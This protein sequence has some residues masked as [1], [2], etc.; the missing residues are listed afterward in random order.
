MSGDPLLEIQNLNK[1]YGT[2][3]ALNGLDMQVFEGDI[4][5]F[6][7]PN[8]SGKSTTIRIILTLI[9]PDKGTIR[10]WKEDLYKRTTHTKKRLGALVEKPD[11]YTYL[12]AYKNLEILTKVGGWQIS[13]KQIMETLDVV[14]LEEVWNKPVKTF[15]QGMRQR[16]GIAQAILHD[17]DLLILDE[18]ANGLDPNGII[19]MRNLILRLNKELNKTIIM[20]SHILKE[21]ELVSNR[22]IV[23]HKGKSV[24]EGYVNELLNKDIKVRI[25][26]D[27][28]EKARNCLL[29]T[30]FS[31][32]FSMIG[33]N[34][35]EM[36]MNPD[37]IPE[38]IKSLVAVDVDV[39][40]A[41][42]VRSLEDY[43]LNIT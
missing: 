41:I 35:I 24:V 6:L 20:S 38:I 42:P 32:N 3:Q 23:I 40:S 39:K 28:Q 22:M 8:G 43:Y 36:D 13:K 29:K 9:F 11:F 17:P 37:R 15:S 34:E 26:V 1:T 2:V 33:N 4:Y 7:G 27:D 10:F 21:V 25:I 12:T 5:G 30:P 19:D 16:L 14:G 18:P 31:E